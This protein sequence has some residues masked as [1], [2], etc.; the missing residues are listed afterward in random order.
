[1]Q[2]RE[3]LSEYNYQTLMRSADV[4]K[5]PEIVEEC[6]KIILEGKK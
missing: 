1:M 4:S 2:C 6:L 3:Q 5:G